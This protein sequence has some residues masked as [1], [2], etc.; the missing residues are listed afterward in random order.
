MPPEDFDL[1]AYLTGHCFNGIHGAP[2]TV[3]LRAHGTTARIFR[4]RIFHPS[5]RRIEEPEGADDSRDETTTTIEMRVARGRG[6]VRFI[7]SWSPDLEVLEP[8][9][10]RREVAAA[11]K[12]SLSR[13]AQ[14]SE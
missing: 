14:A 5:Q 11:H 7:L 10:L 13:L 2:V 6:L 4:E 1:R 9:E 8:S 3:R 12:Q